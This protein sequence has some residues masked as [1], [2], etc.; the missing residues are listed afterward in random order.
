MKME[1]KPRLFRQ[2]GFFLNTC[3]Y[4]VNETTK[5]HLKIKNIKVLNQGVLF[6]VCKS[7]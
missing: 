3:N 5:R 1:I 7:F 6:L 2:S 4:L